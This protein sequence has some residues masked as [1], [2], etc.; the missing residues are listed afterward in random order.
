MHTRTFGTTYLKVLL[1]SWALEGRKEDIARR[2][3]NQETRERMKEHRSLITALGDWSRIVLLDNPAFPE[4]SRRNFAD[5][6]AEMGKTPLDAAYDILLAEIDQLHRPFII[7]HSYTE[8]LL[9]L[10]YEHPFCMVGS[11]ATALA[12]DGPLAGASFHGAYTWAS[13][14]YRRM[15]RENGFFTPE[16]GI[17]KLTGL[18]AERFKLPDRG[19]IRDGA[20]ADLAIF[21]PQTFGE[22]G[23][24]FEPNQVA[25]GMTHVLVNGVPTVIDGRLTGDR[26]GAV[27]RR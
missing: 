21:D 22:K 25:T 14:F 24:I 26:A 27:L 20:W 13:W 12:P 10:T 17:R 1:P 23:T 6:A 2:L 15:V 8:E 5:I 9:K 7:L 11:D 19:V 16:E 18:V 3:A 4:F